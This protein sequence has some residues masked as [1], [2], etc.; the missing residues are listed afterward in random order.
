M[1]EFLL[2]GPI[3]RPFGSS[4][5]LSFNLYCTL[6]LILRPFRRP[7]TPPVSGKCKMADREVD[8]IMDKVGR[9]RPD[10]FEGPAAQDLEKEGT[11]HGQHGDDSERYHTTLPVRT[12]WYFLTC[13]A[14]THN[15]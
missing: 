7:L 13:Q 2:K 12:H 5:I 3:T 14:I 10:A 6:L 8:L 11:G 4:G 1:P 15:R 9:K